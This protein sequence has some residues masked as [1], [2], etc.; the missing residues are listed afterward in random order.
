MRSKRHDRDA[1]QMLFALT[2]AWI[3]AYAGMTF[4]G[5]R[6]LSQNFAPGVKPGCQ[7]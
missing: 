6:C 4:M 2:L 5:M 3:P 7:S 1:S